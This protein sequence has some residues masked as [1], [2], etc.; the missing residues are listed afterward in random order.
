MLS[1]WLA[2]PAFA[3]AAA[4]QA[5]ITWSNAKD[6]LHS[7]T[8]LTLYHGKAWPTLSSICP[9]CSKRKKETFRFGFDDL[10]FSTQFL[11]SDR[12]EVKA[13]AAVTNTDP[14]N[15]FNLNWKRHLPGQRYERSLTA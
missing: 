5:E 13:Y 15:N 7:N 10:A 14:N 3:A 8:I 6:E 11:L 12:D 2:S 4:G 1:P 9:P